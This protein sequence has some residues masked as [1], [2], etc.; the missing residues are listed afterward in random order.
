MPQGTAKDGKRWFKECVAMGKQGVNVTF[1]IV[2][3]IA[4]EANCRLEI[5]LQIAFPMLEAFA[6]VL[7]ATTICRGVE[8][9]LCRKAMV[10]ACLTGTAAI[11]RVEGYQH[12]LSGRQLTQFV[13]GVF[14]PCVY[15]VKKI[16]GAIRFLPPIPIIIIRNNSNEILE[17]PDVGGGNRQQVA[18]SSGCVTIVSVSEIN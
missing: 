10:M 5:D 16:Q 13:R 11:V 4:L 7:A 18:Q 6:I 17:Q 14:A 2:K 1:L 15:A 9:E 8:R 3:P 12:F